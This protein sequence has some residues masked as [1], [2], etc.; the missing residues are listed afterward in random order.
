MGKRVRLSSQ[1]ARMDAGTPACFCRGNGQ[2]RGRRKT[3]GLERSR[4]C[5]ARLQVSNRGRAKDRL[6]VDGDPRPAITSAG[7]SPEYMP[8][9]G[10]DGHA[11]PAARYGG[12]FGNASC[13]ERGTATTH[14]GAS[15][16]E[17]GT[18]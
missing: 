7:E 11:S 5:V 15:A 3:V 10:K 4:H 17:T 13:R 8:V 9:A 12:R 1:D 6:V 18:G 14:R 16:M 2:A